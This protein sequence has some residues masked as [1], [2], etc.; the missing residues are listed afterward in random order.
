MKLINNDP[1]QIYRIDE[2]DEQKKLEEAR[3]RV[4][5]LKK[6]RGKRKKAT[7]GS[8]SPAVSFEVKKKD[9]DD[10]EQPEVTLESCQWE[11]K[12][13]V[14]DDE[15]NNKMFGNGD[16]EGH[17]EGNEFPIGDKQ[18]AL[19]DPP[20]NVEA[21]R[22]EEEEI[23]EETTVTRHEKLIADE[24]V[25]DVSQKANAS[26]GSGKFSSRAEISTADSLFEEGTELL[27][28]LSKPIPLSEEI[29]AENKR[30]KFENME[31]ETTIDELREQNNN[32]SLRLQ[33]LQAQ[34]NAS[35]SQLQQVQAQLQDT[36]N[37]LA[38]QTSQS[39]STFSTGS[40]QENIW[41]NPPQPNIDRDAIRK[42][43]N[44]NLDMTSWRSIGS[45]PIVEF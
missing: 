11:T 9:H 26:S 31:Y 12:S 18:A 1:S 39:N 41:L 8:A 5:E 43:K 28:T 20:T 42:W 19:Y 29:L 15:V 38:H 35:Q 44:W 27:D 4:E 32:L 37:Q 30:L 21:D 13:D 3:K 10:Q 23:S 25:H 6:R 17:L 14:V 45:G 22:D 16:V 2:M 40:E 34:L 24:P 36:Q 33:Q 7:A